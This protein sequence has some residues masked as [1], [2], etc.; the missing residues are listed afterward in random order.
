M[1]VL[2]ID[3]NDVLQ[4]LLPS[5]FS[6]AG[7]EIMITG[8]ILNRE[9]LS[10]LIDSFGPHLVITYGWGPEQTIEKQYIIKSCVR[11]RNIPHVYWSV[12]DPLYT[13]NFVLPLLV[14]AEPDAVFT[15]C[16]SYVDYYRV[17]GFNTAHMDWG[18]APGIH[19]PTSSSSEK[20]V[21]I[22][23]IAN[24]YNWILDEFKVDIRMDSMRAL[25][26]PL[27]ENGLRVDIWGSGWEEMSSYLGIGID[28][29]TLHGPVHF[30]ES[31][32]I[33]NSAKIIIGFQNYE[34]QVTQRTYEVLGSGGFLLTFDTPAVR[35]LFEP[36]RD[37]L[38][39]SSP[40]ETLQIVHHY[41]RAEEER[42]AIARQGH[43]AVSPH[44]YRVRAEYMI[45]VLTDLGLL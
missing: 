6:D 34:N 10:Y 11:E 23:I 33:Y 44:T 18:V 12:E 41:L 32:A 30:F 5:G 45:R 26:L 15:I 21:D 13:E 20:S 3:S 29:S 1:K 38:V 9:H 8:P 39:S 16:S 28:P 4:F 2:F 25:L 17:R 36:G 37:L 24:S 22:A 35:K 31:N 7:H 19:F 43:L 40:Q 14:A 42:K 27:L